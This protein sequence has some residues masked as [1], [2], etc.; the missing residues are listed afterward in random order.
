MNNN[1]EAGL[2]EAIV[3]SLEKA[4]DNLDN[5]DARK[6][7]IQEIEI[8]VKA[9]NEIVRTESEVAAKEVELE[10]EEAKEKLEEKRQKTEKIF[11]LLQI[12]LGILEIGV[13]LV[14]YGCWLG[15]LMRFEE[16]GHAPSSPVFRMFTRELRPKK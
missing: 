10:A 13:P 6:A 4:E 2:E 14:C 9:R 1:L 16:S 5:P 7:A 8:L 12:G 3:D 15:G 11:R